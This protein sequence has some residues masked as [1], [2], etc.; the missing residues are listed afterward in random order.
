MYLTSSQPSAIYYPSAKRTRV[1]IT[2]FGLLISGF[3]VLGFIG[4][5]LLIIYAIKKPWDTNEKIF[6]EIS[7]IR[8]DIHNIKT[9][10][11]QMR[12]D[13]FNLKP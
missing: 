11:G 9:D 4:T 12:H 5:I 8:G 6:N 13:F 1:M 7:K 2:I 3:A 10:M